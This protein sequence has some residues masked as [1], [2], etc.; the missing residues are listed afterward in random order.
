[1][2][3]LVLHKS[4]TFTNNALVH[5]TDLLLFKI[6]SFMTQPLITDLFGATATFSGSPKVLQ[7]PL[8]SLPSLTGANP[9]ALELYAA[10]V[11]N[12]HTWLNANTDASVLGTSDLTISS[13]VT[14]NGVVKTQFQYSERFYGSYTA[15]TFD[16]NAV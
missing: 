14:R 6:F 2:I 3:V 16:P 4:G 13:P 9:T 12:A 11:S 15:P 8:A 1:M 5:K 10:I 7:I